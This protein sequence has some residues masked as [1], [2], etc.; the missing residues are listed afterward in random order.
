MR[1]A[2]RNAALFATRFLLSTCIW[3]TRI[4]HL[5]TT[6]STVHGLTRHLKWVKSHYFAFPIK[7]SSPKKM[8]RPLNYRNAKFRAVFFFSGRK[9]GGN[10]EKLPRWTRRVRR[11]DAARVPHRVGAHIC[12]CLVLGA[13]SGHHWSR[14]PW[15]FLR[16]FFGSAKMMME[17]NTW[18]LYTILVLTIWFI[19]TIYTCL[20]FVRQWIQV[21]ASTLKLQVHHVL[22]EQ[23]PGAF[24]EPLSQILEQMGYGSEDQGRAVGGGRA[25]CLVV[26]GP[27][28]CA[29]LGGRMPKSVLWMLWNC[30]VRHVQHFVHLHVALDVCFF[31]QAQWTWCCDGR[32]KKYGCYSISY[33]SWEVFHGRHNDLVTFSSLSRC[34]RNLYF[35]VAQYLVQM[36]RCSATKPLQGYETVAGPWCLAVSV[37]F[38][39]S[40]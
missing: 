24:D 40:L 1:I 8:K 39:F 21:V 15:C 28:Q 18:K 11:S 29:F 10:G 3:P 37:P 35:F 17:E 5:S 14:V 12:Q 7:L 2:H 38:C 27:W 13:A 26:S 36:V 16:F 33:N 30:F 19:Y 20:F 22:A 32:L 6:F 25:V 31:W 34:L 9:R 4:V 23:D